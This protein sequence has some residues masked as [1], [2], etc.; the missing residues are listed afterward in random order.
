MGN[1]WKDLKPSGG[2]G[3]SNVLRVDARHPWDLYWALGPGG[4]PQLACRLP[5][6]IAFPNPDEIPRVKAVEIRLAHLH[7]W[8]WCV[9]ELQDR[10]FEDI[11]QALCGAL[12]EAARMVPSIEGVMHVMVRHLARW[13]R[14]LSRTIAPGKMKFQEQI[15]LI[16]ELVFLYNHIMEIIPIR[17]SVASWVA[18]QNH[19]QDFM[20]PGGSVVEVK[21]RQATA[22]DII[23]ISSQWQLH[24]E[25]LPLFLTVFTLAAGDRGQGFS[26]HSL[27]QDIR[28]RLEKDIVVLDDLEVALVHRGYIDTPEEYDQRWW[29]ICGIRCFSV[30]G[31]FPRLEPSSLPAGIIEVG[32]T[33]SLPDCEPWSVGME[34][35]LT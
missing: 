24:Q 26:L 35:V 27:V 8:R 20:L 3:Q 6:N 28:A 7:P 13:Q 31:N 34:I 25:A 2:E 10:A 16:G 33:I 21:C 17:E 32:Y 5:E 12:V 18:S 9:V 15:G 14:M 29:A 23:H 30:D 1:P 22:A 19:P 4:Q 11:F